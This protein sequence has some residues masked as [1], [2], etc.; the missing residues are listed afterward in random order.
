MNRKIAL[1][2]N[3]V[4]AAAAV[5]GTTACAIMFAMAVRF[6]ELGRAIFYFMLAS[7][8]VETS[9]FSIANLIGKRK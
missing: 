2:W 3:I 9:I 4:V 5:A 6:G 7:L 8:C 1:I